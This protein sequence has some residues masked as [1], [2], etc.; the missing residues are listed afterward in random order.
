MKLRFK[1][2]E[3][4]IEDG[5]DVI[6]CDG[7]HE[8]KFITFNNLELVIETAYGNYGGFQEYQI[9]DMTIKRRD[10]EWVEPQIIVRHGGLLCFATPEKELWDS[11]IEY[12]IE[13]GK[14]FIRSKNE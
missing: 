12:K 8:Y 1:D 11:N 3:K 10:E 2:I 5:H 6:L 13:D 9:T 4:E 14:I 7:D